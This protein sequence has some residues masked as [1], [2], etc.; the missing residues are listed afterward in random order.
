MFAW[1][2][3]DV[4]FVFMRACSEL[5]VSK[6]KYIFEEKTFFSNDIGNLASQ[7][8]KLSHSF[9]NMWIFYLKTLHANIVENSIFLQITFT[10]N[11]LKNLSLNITACFIFRRKKSKLIEL[12]SKI[13]L[14]WTNFFFVLNSVELIRLVTSSANHLVRDQA[15]NLCILSKQTS[16]YYILENYCY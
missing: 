2:E 5:S 11:K 8:H 4:N 14:K 3:A 12:C 9:E 16:S 13:S 10:D 1:L 6:K 15:Q 7:Q